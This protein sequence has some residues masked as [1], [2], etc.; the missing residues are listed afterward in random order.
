MPAVITDTMAIAITL[1]MPAA[2][3]IAAAILAKTNKSR[4]G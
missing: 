1:A 2:L 4:H 3:L